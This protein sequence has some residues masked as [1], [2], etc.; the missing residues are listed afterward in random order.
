MNRRRV[1]SVIGAGV[2]ILGLTRGAAAATPSN[3]DIS[4]PTPI[5]LP[6]TTYQSTVEATAGPTDPTDCAAGGHSVWFSHTATADGRLLATTFGSD[7]DTVLI[8]GTADGSGGI[9]VLDCNDD[10]FDLQSAVRF[11]AVAGTTYLLMVGSFS[12]SSGG[13]LVMNLS[14]APPAPSVD[15][16]VDSTGSFTPYGIA[17]L[18]GTVTCGGG[19]QLA[20]LEASLAQTVGRVVIRGFGGTKG[21][22]C[23]PS[24]TPWELTIQSDDGKFLGGPA[25]AHVFVFACNDLEC[26]ESA[27]QQ[28]VRLRR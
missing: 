20:T 7:Y 13:E 16:T 26:V 3:D 25:E 15:I 22:E 2:L 6:S 11:D 27:V 1:A 10:A 14:V 21:S 24:P 9:T 19:A 28:S 12:E 17:T 18:R 8:V 23:G 4:T 5:L